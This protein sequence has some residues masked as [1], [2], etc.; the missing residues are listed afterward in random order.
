MWMD[1]IYGGSIPRVDGEKARQKGCDSWSTSSLGGVS[2]AETS[3][4][5]IEDM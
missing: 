4:P 3:R 5:C 1:G 2:N